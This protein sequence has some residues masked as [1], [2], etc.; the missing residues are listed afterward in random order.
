MCANETTCDRNLLHQVH[1][2][3]HEPK[4]LNEGSASVAVTRSTAANAART[5]A[6]LSRYRSGREARCCGCFFASKI[7]IG[8]AGGPCDAFESRR[9]KLTT[10]SRPVLLLVRVRYFPGTE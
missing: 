8:C 5:R 6:E 9:S 7:C 10:R 4:V 3:A 1:T 2:R